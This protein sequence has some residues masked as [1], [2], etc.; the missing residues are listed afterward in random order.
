MGTLSTLSF[1]GRFLR[2]FLLGTFSQDLGDGLDHGR[3]VSRARQAISLF[4]VLRIGFVLL[5]IALVGWMMREPVQA[6][7]LGAV[8]LAVAALWFAARASARRLVL[9]AALRPI[10]ET[11]AL[12]E[13]SITASRFLPGRAL[14]TLAVATDL[15]RRGQAADA[16][17]L[18]ATIDEPFLEPDEKRLL[19]GLRA[20]IADREGDTLRAAT[21]ALSAFPVGAPDIDERLGRIFAESAWHD[22]T[23][24]SRAYDSWSEVG[25]EPAMAT[26]V[27]R[28]LMLIDLKLGRAEPVADDREAELLAEEALA[29]GDRELADRAL[30]VVRAR[31]PERYR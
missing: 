24:L 16:S 21:N 29:L 27:G 28:L 10:I 20:I 11:P 2:W 9:D 6:S 1:I 18:I 3:A 14:Q 7:A 12:G 13:A 4:F 25:Y 8:G 17:R 19:V 22:A 26:P 15:T 5:V 31:R 23:R 30:A